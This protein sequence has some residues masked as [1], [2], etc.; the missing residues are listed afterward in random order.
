MPH[1]LVHL[2]AGGVSLVL[3]CRDRALPAVVHWGA[4]LGPLDAAE[5]A[6]LAE[7]DVAPVAPNEADVPVRLAIL[8]EPHR[9]WTGRPGLSG[10]RDGRD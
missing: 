10:H 2:T 7:A 8:P 6:A 9:G 1:D 5:L 4:A 3:D